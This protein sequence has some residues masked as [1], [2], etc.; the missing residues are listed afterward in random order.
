[1]SQE[2]AMNQERGPINSLDS[3]NHRLKILQID[4][5]PEYLCDNLF[6]N[7]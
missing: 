4:R 6:E 3:A 7:G 5:P 2:V 1:M